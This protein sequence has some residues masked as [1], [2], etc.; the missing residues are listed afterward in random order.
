MRYTLIMEVKSQTGGTKMTI[1]P[2][3]S[4]EELIALLHESANLI[5]MLKPAG[6]NY[7]LVKRITQ[8]L[9]R[10]GGGR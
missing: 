4:R 3:T 6:A 2:Q 5:A 8:A 7:P 9:A 1:Q 10:A